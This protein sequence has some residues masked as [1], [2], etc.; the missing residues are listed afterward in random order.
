MHICTQ[1]KF[2]LHFPHN[3]LAKKRTRETGKKIQNSVFLL[4][5]FLKSTGLNKRREQTGNLELMWK[6]NT[7]RSVTNETT[8]IHFCKPCYKRIVLH[9]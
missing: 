7:C 9:I 2:K 3:L 5:E 1:G 4:M 6:E 8:L